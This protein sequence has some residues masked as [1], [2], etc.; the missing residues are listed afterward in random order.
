MVRLLKQKYQNKIYTQKQP[1][2]PWINTYNQS[3]LRATGSG[4]YNVNLYDA[5]KESYKQN[6]NLDK[7]GF[8]LHKN[9]S[10]SNYQTYFKPSTKQLLF[11]IKGTDLLSPRD[12]TTDFYLA[13]GNLKNTTRLKEAASALQKAKDTLQP[14]HTVVA[15]HS[16]GGAIAQYIAS[17]S[18]KVLTLDKGATIN[19]PTRQNET[20]Y[21]TKG[22]IVSSLAKDTITLENKSSIPYIPILS[23]Y[24]AH[25]ID[26][27]KNSNI[28]F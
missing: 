19:Q 4:L 13:F 22:D 20:A 7:F 9:L 11:V 28:I 25:D 21:R 8:T 1:I 10:S 27:I 2:K 26:N 24:L 18:D 14:L 16:L 12:V 17:G 15:G 3:I 23:E 6:P 5:L